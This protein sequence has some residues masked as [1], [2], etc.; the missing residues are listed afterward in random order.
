[1]AGNIVLGYDGSDGSKAALRAAISVAH[2]YGAPLSIVF[3]YEN[4]P[5]SAESQDYHTEVQKMGNAF[6]DEAAEEVSRSEPSLETEKLVV[7]MRAVDALLEAAEEREARVI[8]VGGMG[9]APIL[10]AILGSV[11]HKLLH[12]AKVPVLVVP[13]EAGE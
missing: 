9:E 2:A 6:V 13:V 8:V 5:L 1:M 3:G 10:G 12:R 11:P 7:P 4:A